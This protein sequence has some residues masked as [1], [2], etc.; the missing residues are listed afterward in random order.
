MM[1]KD[2]LRAPKVGVPVL[3]YVVSLLASIY[4]VK[5]LNPTAAVAAL[6]F[7]VPAAALVW[8]VVQSRRAKRFMGSA[9]CGGRAY[10]R[11]IVV[12]ALSYVA[13][14]LLAIWL[15]KSYALSG[16]VAVVVA[17]LPALP[18][19]GMI[20]AMA[21][22]IIDTQDEYQRML[23]VRQMLVATGFTLAVC[24][25]WGFL[26]EFGL[27]MHLPAYWTFV[28]WCGGLAIGT[29]YNEARP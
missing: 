23:H 9:P 22:L 1:P 19:V 11:R 24:S 7:A 10:A 8:M 4:L 15:N 13:L 21:R 25:V 29:I 26:E 14:L 12:L 2:E 16:P 20:V 6:I 28:L 17:L 3:A 27:V 18:L 5:A